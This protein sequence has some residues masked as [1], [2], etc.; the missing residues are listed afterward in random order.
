MK[1]IKSMRADGN[2]P[3]IVI[4]VSNKLIDN[5]I[6]SDSHKCMIA[7]AIKVRIPKAQF[8]SVDVQ[9]IRFTNPETRIRYKYFTPLS[10]QQSLVNFDLG[11]KVK[12]FA[13]TLKDGVKESIIKATMKRR[14]RADSRKRTHM[15]LKGKSYKSRTKKERKY[16]LRNIE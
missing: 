11:K 5:A 13:L 10:G 9:S 14:K 1:K 15:P 3:I 8:I 6:R 12:P 2:M 7:D 16:G 4:P